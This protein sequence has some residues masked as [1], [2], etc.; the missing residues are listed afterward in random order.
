MGV[1]E[2]TQVR[3]TLAETGMQTTTDD[4]D[5]LNFLAS[6]YSLDNADSCA[7]T[8]TDG[9][10]TIWEINR[11]CQSTCSGVEPTHYILK[12]AEEGSVKLAEIED[13]FHGKDASE[14]AVRVRWPLVC[15][16][17]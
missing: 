13:E 12:V 14:H 3:P 5:R 6:H 15:K 4:N 9:L 17:R 10:C 8:K 11:A 7:S 2:E 1:E 16:K